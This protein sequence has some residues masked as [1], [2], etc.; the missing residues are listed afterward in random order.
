MAA[1]L[2]SKNEKVK[3]VAKLFSN[4]IS[5]CSGKNLKKKK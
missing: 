5:S 1:I 4:S 2:S 3:V